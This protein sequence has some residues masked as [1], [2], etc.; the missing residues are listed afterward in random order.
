M[1]NSLMAKI[2]RNRHRLGEDC[3]S[4]LNSL[5]G[6]CFL[7]FTFL[8]SANEIDSTIDVTYNKGELEGLHSVLVFHK[9]EIVT[10]KYFSGKD[11][12]WGT[13]LG[14]REFNAAS[15]HDIRS[16]TKSITALLYGI[17]LSEGLV[18]GPDSVLVDQ[19]PQYED[20]VKDPKRRKIKIKHALSM[21]MGL[22]WDESMPYSDPRNSEIAM[23]NSA[24][25][26]RYALDRPMVS[27]PGKVFNYSGG[28]PTL[29][30]KIISD[31]VNKSLHEYAKEK[32]F[33]PL[34]I[35][36]TQWIHGSDD[37]PSA[38]AG[39]RMTARD[40][41]KIG[42]MLLNKGK[43][44]QQQI[45]PKT[46]VKE[47]FTQRTNRPSSWQFGYLW[48]LSP[49][50]VTPSSFDG[51]G[52]GGQRLFI[53]SEAEL[54][55]VIYAGKYNVMDAWTMPDKIVNEIIVPAFYSPKNSE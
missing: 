54:V 27:E 21:T 35:V 14:M 50:D 45:I 23:E 16:I 43:Y 48:W 10:E 17:A 52:N 26:Y 34:G 36:N 51:F 3:G 25:R 15:L 55:I 33:E 46:W 32:L 49:E 18:A 22:Q 4:G 47:I 41:A 12:T 30:G 29:I 8:S 28:A 1:Q 53:S 6:L 42:L 31:S 39:L 7:L 19:F 2:E 11:Y 20:L 44:N 24:D 9:G 5:L 37:S 13:N 38:A 40:L